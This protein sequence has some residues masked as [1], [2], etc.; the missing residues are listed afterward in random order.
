MPLEKSTRTPG[1]TM[2]ISFVYDVLEHNI[3]K[4]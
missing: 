3:I 2:R 1:L 4:V